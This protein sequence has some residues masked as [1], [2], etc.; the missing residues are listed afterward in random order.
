MTSALSLN[1]ED[2]YTEQIQNPTMLR[3]FTVSCC[4]SDKANSPI[5]FT[6]CWMAASVQL[7]H[8]VVARRNSIARP[9]V[10]NWWE[11]WVLVFLRRRTSIQGLEKFDESRLWLPLDM[12]VYRCISILNCRSSFRTF[13]CWITFWLFSFVGLSHFKRFN[14]LSLTKCQNKAALSIKFM[15]NSWCV[16]ACKF[17]WNRFF[18]VLSVIGIS[19]WRS[20]ACFLFFF[21]VEVLTQAPRATTVHAI[22]FVWNFVC[23]LMTASKQLL[24]RTR[25]AN[26]M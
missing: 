18:F 14:D 10:E 7:L 19:F 2:S 22:R 13:A 21:Q 26:K 8:S 11:W 23:F 15:K 17:I 20:C 5:V 9:A 3:F 16:R 25:R 12:G 4:F 6:L 24:Q 1:T